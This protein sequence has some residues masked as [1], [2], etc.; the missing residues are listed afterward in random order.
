MLTPIMI[1]RLLFKCYW[2]S[3]PLDNMKNIWA[4]QLL[5]GEKKNLT[6][7][8]LKKGFGRNYRGGRKNSFLRLVEEVLIKSIIQAIPT[9]SMSYFKL[10]K[11]LIK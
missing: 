4:F 9:Y 5:V 1:S 10:P 2:M 7:S 8:I 11:G 6:L 3:H